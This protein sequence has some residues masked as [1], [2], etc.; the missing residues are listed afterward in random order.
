VNVWDRQPDEPTRWFERF[1]QFCLMGPGRTL[2]GCIHAEQE[3]LGKEKKSTQIPG[4][5]SEQAARWKWRERATAWDDYQR[6]LARK[7]EEVTLRQRRRVHLAQAQ[8]VQDKAFERLKAIAPAELT[9]RDVLAYLEAGVRQE[10]LARG[11]PSEITE[12]RRRELPAEQVDDDTLA[13]IAVEGSQDAATPS[14]DPQA[15]SHTE[16][17]PEG[18]SE[19]GNGMPPS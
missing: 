4:A 6:E 3:R 11:A 9:V 16:S 7:E 15:T 5:W 10:L 13:R 19:P 8:L 18:K 2:M 17:S 1:H 12:E 14:D